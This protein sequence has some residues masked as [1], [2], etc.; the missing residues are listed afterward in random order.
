VSDVEEV[1]RAAYAGSVDSRAMFR[2][3]SEATLLLAV[4]PGP[5]GEL[6]PYAFS[7][8]GWDSGAVFTSRERTAM[9]PDAADFLPMVG[10]ELG[11]RWPDGLRAL[12]NPGS[13]PLARAFDDEAMH[14]LAD[15]DSVPDDQPGGTAMAPSAITSDAAPAGGGEVSG[16]RPFAVGAPP[17][18][19]PDALVAAVR[20]AVQGTSGARGAYVFRFLQPPD[21]PRLVVGVLTD[22]GAEESATRD[23]INAVVASYPPAVN[24][25][26]LPLDEQL[27]ALVAPH[28]PQLR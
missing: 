28:V 3:L 15:P 13:G 2:A 16:G 25:D 9:L 10:R 4:Q 17:E 1:L 23:V 8:N 19:P 12:L 7:W 26:F 22:P 18:P 20:R 14:L 24:L 21:E 27:R 11:R 5:D 6:E